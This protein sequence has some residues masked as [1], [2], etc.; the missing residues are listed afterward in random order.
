MKKRTTGQL[1]AQAREQL[2]LNQSELARRLRVTPQS[3]QA[4]ES[5]RNT[6]R[7]KKLKEIGDELGVSAAYLLGE[8]G[9]AASIDDGGS[10]VESALSPIRFFEYP[11]I[12]WVQAGAASEVMEISNVSASPKH[13]SDVWAGHDGFWLRVVGNSMTSPAGHSFPEGFLILVAPETEPRSG[14]FVIAR[15]VDSNEATFKQFLR[16]AGRFYLK[17]LN[18]SFPTI[19]MND[20]WEIVG[21]VVDGKMP[22]SVFL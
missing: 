20:E 10:N 12:S 17:P 5:D 21:T 14:Q 16:D 22:N 3:V 1:I 8:D 6:P 7:H 2:G 9:R 18:P 11:E 4:W 15:T 13:R 19:P